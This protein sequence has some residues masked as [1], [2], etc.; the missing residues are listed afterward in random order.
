MDILHIFGF[1]WALLGY[2]SA[3]KIIEAEKQ[4]LGIVYL[5][6]F[7][8]KAQHHFREGK[9]AVAV[10]EIAK[11]SM[12]VLGMITMVDLIFDIDL[13]LPAILIL[14]IVDNIILNILY[15]P[16]TQPYPPNR[17]TSEEQV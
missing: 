7:F 3:Q 11:I 13:V 15:P 17:E 1:V 10:G 6:A 14:I 4:D 8:T 9:D 12:A 5:G 16:Q 2:R